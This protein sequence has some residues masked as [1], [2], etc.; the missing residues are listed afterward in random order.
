M[1]KMK[2]MRFFTPARVLSIGFAVLILVGAILLSLPIASQ[3]GEGLRFVDALLEATSA[4]CVTGLI[5]VDTG[6]YFNH[7][8]QIV[9]ISLIQIGGL[10]FMTLATFIT[11]MTGRKIGLKE[12]LLIQEALN[13]SS[14]E[15]LIRLSRNVVLITLGIEFF[16]G[17]ILATRFSFDMPLG[18][19]IYYGMFHSVSAFCNAGFDLFGGFKSIS[20]YVGDPTVN[21]SI[22]FL[23][24]LGG[25]GF[26]VL[27]DMRHVFLRKRT[28][29]HTK[30]V[31]L[32]S[33]VL[34]VIG[35]VGYYL[36]EN[37]N[38]GTIGN[39]SEGTKWLASFF[40]STTARTAGYA[41]VNYETMSQGGL[42]WTIILMFIGA[43]PGST[44]GGI[45]TV[46]T[47]VI[48]LYIVTVIT[49]KER[50]VVFGRSIAPQMIYKSL[51]IAVMALL[52]VTFSTMVLTVTENVDFLRLLFETTS[53]FATV[54]LSTNL[55]P[56]LSDP[57]KALIIILMYIGR[58]GPLTIA[59][60]L[61][62]RYADKANLKYPEGSLYVG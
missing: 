8:G 6:T 47:F 45:K 10:G 22:G 40:A 11:I 2:K 44:G 4:V 34:L 30:I 12:R 57:G 61:A 25:I 36:F 9:L 35:T 5:V 28:M 55:T 58:L 37:H 38:P 17:L 20:D 3:S 23:I 29:L 27:A 51:V 62:A 56:T 48:L 31:L 60:A 14:L 21:I 33:A 13:V 42:L 50:P 16:F 43:S 46:T 41:S 53:A 18:R 19:A 26:T 52:L 54:G 1:Q 49:N 59:L 24:I 39:F 15:G 7:F 32:V